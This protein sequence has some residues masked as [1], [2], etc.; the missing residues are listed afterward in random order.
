MKSQIKSKYIPVSESD[1]ENPCF[2]FSM[3]SNALLGGIVRGEL[4]AIELAKK[5]LANRGY[6]ENGKWV[7]FKNK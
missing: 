5:E 3:V 2:L 7:G 6:D 1:Y 4:N